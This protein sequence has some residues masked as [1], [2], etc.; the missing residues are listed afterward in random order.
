[1]RDDLRQLATWLDV[2][3]MTTQASGQRDALLAVARTMLILLGK[4][5]A[6]IETLEEKQNEL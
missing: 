4:M 5:V 6:T 2:Y 3:K 1:M